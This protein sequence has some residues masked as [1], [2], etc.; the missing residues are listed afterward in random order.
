MK[1]LL[2]SIALFFILFIPGL[3][4]RYV[5]AADAYF[6][7]EKTT[8]VSDRTKVLEKNK[9]L[10][11]SVG[12]LIGYA[13]SFVGTIFFILVIYGGFK[14]MTASGNPKTVSSAQ[15]MIVQAIIGLIVIFSAY[16]LTSYIGNTITK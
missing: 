3:T 7:L 15:E 16:I 9:D 8:A 13:L 11:A 5:T 4:V 12:K 2:V 14:W 1:K 6:G 10:Q